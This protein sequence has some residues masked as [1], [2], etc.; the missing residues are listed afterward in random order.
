MSETEIVK[1]PQMYKYIFIHLWKYLNFL[2]AHLISD[3]HHEGLYLHI[4]QIMGNTQQ[5]DEFFFFLICVLLLPMLFNNN[6]LTIEL[7][8][9]YLLINCL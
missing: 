6:N 1:Y 2:T 3:Y 5:I 4:D 8:P 7:S 9:H